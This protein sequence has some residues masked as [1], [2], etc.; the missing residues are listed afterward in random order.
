MELQSQ[1]KSL[2]EKISLL[3]D[4]IETE[5]ST[6]H[7]FVLPFINILGYDAFNPL[8]V[9]PE[10]TADLGLKKGEK[11][12][13]AI[14]QNGEPILII[15][16][17]N[18][19][20]PL[21]V[22]N[23]QLFR[24][25]HVTQTRFSLLTNGIQ[26]QFFTDLENKN[27]MDEKP[28][29]EF[30]ITELKDSVINEIAKFHRSNFDIDKIINNASSLKYTREIKNAINSEITSP[31]NEF[32]RLFA[33]KAYSGRLTEK[34]LEEFKELVQKAFSQI[35]SEKINDR[36][37]SALKKESV[38]QKVENIELED[39]AHKIETTEEELEAFRIVVAILRRKLNVERI[40]YRDTQSYFGI[41]LDDNNRK[42]L[43]RLHLNG[44]KKYIGLFDSERKELR[45]QIEKLE[46]IYEFEKELLETVDYYEN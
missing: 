46:D 3:K 19:K 4:K 33:G 9:V 38:Q 34:I 15:E 23:S 31:S 18:W 2:A 35:I 45:K 8:E 42:P 7:A 13:Y 32:A 1:L 14:F 25:F 28:F 37:N 43:C 40:V 6:K 17:K 29:L 44:G 26:Y 16:C 12:D 5:E 21:T 22:H 10:F 36:L 41:L 20:E 30:D 39:D 11:V 27:K 24:Y